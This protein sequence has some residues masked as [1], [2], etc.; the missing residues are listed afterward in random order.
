MSHDPSADRRAIIDH[1]HSIFQAYI[2][3]DRDALRRTHSSDWTGFQLPSA[4]IER[5]I[6]D[7]MRNAEDS[8]RR[9]RGTGY[10]LGDTE[11]QLFGDMA[12]LWYVG[13]YDFADAE[14]M[15]KSLGLRSVD[16]YRR[17]PT[18]WN[19]CGSHI[20]RVPETIST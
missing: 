15:P 16:V 6:D 1:V 12:L 19:Q 11:I 8:F 4:R 7:Y 2:R 9:F 3:R 10:E 20:T 14:G 13:R 18:G 17:E 5:G